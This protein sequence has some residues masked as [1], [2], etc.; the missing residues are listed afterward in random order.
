MKY[1]TI[2]ELEAVWAILREAEREHLHLTIVDRLAV[3]EI[4][5]DRLALLAKK[6]AALQE[7]LKLSE[8]EVDDG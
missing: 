4:N 2:T 7:E 6:I 5:Q 1:R 8:H 3:E